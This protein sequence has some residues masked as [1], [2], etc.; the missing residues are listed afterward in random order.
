MGLPWTT[1][2]TENDD[3]GVDSDM[4]EKLFRRI[5]ERK[6]IPELTF[7]EYFP[8]SEETIVQISV[9]EKHVFI[10]TRKGNMYIAGSNACGQLGDPSIIPSQKYFRR[11][12]FN[13]PVTAIHCFANSTFWITA[14]GNVFVCGDN[15]NAELGIRSE[16]L[17]TIPTYHPIL[18]QQG[19]EQIVG[20][21]NLFALSKNGKIFCWGSNEENELGVPEYDSE[22]VDTPVRHFSLERMGNVVAH[23]GYKL[24]VSPGFDH[25]FVYFKKNSKHVT[26]LLENLDK[27]CREG[28]ASRFE[29]VSFIFPKDNSL[30]FPNATSL[31][32]MDEDKSATK[33]K[34]PPT[35][36][37]FDYHLTHDQKR[38]KQ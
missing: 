13:E 21:N 10:L 38:L 36:S 15:T 17:L 20:N 4:T 32:N 26:Y 31:D 12:H 18:S 16:T 11:H 35:N 5:E 30:S 34:E 28:T 14:K 6:I 19:I 22:R 2:A 24:Y 1:D 33:R 23:R 8:Y 29:D 27:A 37:T 7:V 3:V 25:T 9:G